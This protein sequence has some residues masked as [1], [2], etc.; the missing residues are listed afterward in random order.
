MEL[1]N[2]I[3]TKN[4]ISNCNPSITNCLLSRQW[5]TYSRLILRKSRTS[6]APTTASQGPTLQA[7]KN[8]LKP[9]LLQ[10]TTAIM[11]GK[12]VPQKQ[13]ASIPNTNSL[14]VKNKDKQ[15]FTVDQSKPVGRAGATSV[16]DTKDHSSP[17][18]PTVMKVS[19]FRL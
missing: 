1:S 18:T 9:S 3:S 5:G 17:N 13:V 7:A 14:A 10:K 6:T 19:Q 16:F 4:E 8:A 11:S 2:I 15:V 12:S